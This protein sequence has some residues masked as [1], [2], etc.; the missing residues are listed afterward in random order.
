VEPAGDTARPDTPD[1]GPIKRG[2]F[3][4][5]CRCHPV[6]CA[7]GDYAEDELVGSSCWTVAS[8]VGQL[9]CRNVLTVRFTLA[10]E[11]HAAVLRHLRLWHRGYWTQAVV[12]IAFIAA[13]ASLH[14]SQIAR[15]VLIGAG[16]LWLYLVGFAVVLG[17]TLEARKAA[18]QRTESM[19]QFSEDGLVFETA[20]TRH[21]IGWT[22]IARLVRAGSVSVLQHKTGGYVYMIPD[23][24]FDSPDSASRFTALA[25][26]MSA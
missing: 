3:Y 17:P 15:G 19:Y 26:L 4:E 25:T 2:D 6:L 23:R 10:P 12:G 20:A 1:P 22:D 21:S 9:G 18:P 8:R 13:A 11:E 16:A 14:G 7:T 5:D 24:A